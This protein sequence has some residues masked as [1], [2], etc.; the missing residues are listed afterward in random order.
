MMHAAHMQTA[1]HALGGFCSSFWNLDKGVVCVA[2]GAELPWARD[3]YPLAAR[4]QFDGICNSMVL[5]NGVAPADEA[6]LS[7]L[8]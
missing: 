8:H 1:L 2:T 4:C 6:A 7:S 5:T 3:L